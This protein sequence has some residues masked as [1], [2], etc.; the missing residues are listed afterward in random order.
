MHVDI[1]TAA[2]GSSSFEDAV[3]STSTSCDTCGAKPE[4]L[5]IVLSVKPE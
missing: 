4:R 2:C 1:H 5:L 3:Y